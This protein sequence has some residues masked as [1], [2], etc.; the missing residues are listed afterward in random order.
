M[1]I[2]RIIFLSCFLL[3]AVSTQAKVYWVGRNIDISPEKLND[4]KMLTILGHSYLIL[5]PD[6]P[7]QI[8]NIYPTYARF[9]KQLGCD[10]RGVVIGAY[11]SR[12]TEWLGDLDG[13]LVAQIN[14]ER[15]NIPTAHFFCGTDEQKKKWRKK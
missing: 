11:P 10:K 14:A 5:I 13:Y 8:K 15:E 1:N 2:F 9:E 7:E 3:T 6:E 4:K 12:G